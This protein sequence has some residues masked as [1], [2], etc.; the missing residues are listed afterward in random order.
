[1]RLCERIA[2]RVS[3]NPAVFA[4]RHIMRVIPWLGL[5]ELGVM[6]LTGGVPPH[7]FRKRQG[8]FEIGRR[9][10]RIRYEHSGRGGRGSVQIVRMV[11]GRTLGPVVVEI[12][13]LR[14]AEAFYLDPSACLRSGMPTAV[15]RLR[16]VLGEARA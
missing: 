16:R 5:I 9:T 1:M 12:A 13:G 2:Y 15:E 6:K 4:H 11:D 14:E 7:S 8:Q 10:Y 3:T